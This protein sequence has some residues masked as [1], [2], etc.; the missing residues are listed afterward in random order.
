M[1]IHANKTFTFITMGL[2]HETTFKAILVLFLCN[3]TFRKNPVPL[4]RKIF[5]VSYEVFEFA[6]NY[7]VTRDGRRRET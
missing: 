3:H 5:G 7:K 6:R 4:H 1:P 2:L